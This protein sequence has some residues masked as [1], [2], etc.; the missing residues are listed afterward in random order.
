MP[1]V[2]GRMRRAEW[3]PLVERFRR[4][5]TGWKGQCLSYGGRVTLIH[6]VLSSL[7]LFFLSVFRVPVGI[8]D[9]IEV[10]RRRFLWQGA[11]EGPRKP[12]L[13][14][15]STVCL[16]KEDG[17]LGILDLRD[18][19]EA[20]LS[21]WLWRWL[22]QPEHTWAT[23]V[24]DRYGGHGLGGRR[25]PAIGP[26]TSALCKGLFGGCAGFVQGVRWGI[27]GGMNV[28]FWHEIWCGEQVLSVQFPAVYGIAFDQ[29]G[30]IGGF[31]SGE[32]SNGGWSIGLRRSHLLPVER[33][34]HS[35]LLEL[36]AAWGGNFNASPDRPI[37]I[38]K[39]STRFSVK[40]CYDWRRRGL[41]AATLGCGLASRIWKPKIPRK[42]KV[43]LWLLA[44]ERLLTRVLRSKWR[45]DDN[46]LCDL[47]GEAP[48]TVAHLFCQC[49]VARAFW[50]EVEQATS[51]IP[52]LGLSEMW[53]VG[54][55]LGKRMATGPRKTIAHLIIPAGAWAIWLT[56]NE[57]IFKGKRVYVENMWVLA[58]AMIR[59]SARVLVGVRGVTLRGGDIS[60]TM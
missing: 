42:I 1:L 5:L 36:L 23:I 31:R 4:R 47:C 46:A 20:L 22:C 18:M 55:E 17:G 15:W 26:R 3:E 49:R 50:R 28:S 16:R 43:F 51:L 32:G 58:A 7:P 10:I 24:R 35:G 57:V 33:S 11:H 19:N 52:F 45:T 48:E 27:G 9:R 29:E 25:W 2:C 6:A 14:A 59:D 34:Q 12:H 44:H 60:I 39:Q 41:P 8:L 38:P 40:S 30:P 21:K 13:V 37:W 54:E 56:R 53:E